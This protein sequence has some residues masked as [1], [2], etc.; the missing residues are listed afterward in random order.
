[1][2]DITVE[3]TKLIE[4]LR[5]NR[6]AH[7]KIFLEAQDGYRA[8][9][10]AEFEKRLR[11]MRDGKKFSVTVHL[12]APMDQTK[13]YDRAIAMLEMSENAMIELS[14]LDFRCYVMDEWSWK[15][16]FNTSNRGYSL[17]L[18]SS[19]GSQDEEEPT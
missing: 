2:N 18:A 1:M 19:L 3:K 8:A 10:I 13:D 4:A 5:K 15:H 6:E 17:S 16:Q 11:A 9:A 7:R 12:V 14:E